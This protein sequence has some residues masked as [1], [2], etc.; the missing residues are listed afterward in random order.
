[1]ERGYNM[2]V[3]CEGAERGSAVRGC[4]ANVPAEAKGLVVKYSC[5]AQ[6]AVCLQSRWVARGED[7]S[8]ELIL[9]SIK[10]TTSSL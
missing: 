8:A 3:Q 10:R 6:S 1:M 4:E 2:K 9:G 5:T 7:V